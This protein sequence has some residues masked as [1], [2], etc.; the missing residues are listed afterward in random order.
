MTND[1]KHGEC[2]LYR[3]QNGNKVYEN[4][5]KIGEVICCEHGCFTV[6]DKNP[7]EGGY[8]ELDLEPVVTH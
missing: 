5:V 6:I 2:P 3:Y 1:D 8:W 7:I 4:D